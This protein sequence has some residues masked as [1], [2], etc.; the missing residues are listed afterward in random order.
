MKYLFATFSLFFM[1][2]FSACTWVKPVEEAKE[3]ALVKP[4]LAQ[5]CKKIS[6]VT[7]KV[8]DSVGFINR[9]DGKVQD[10]LITMAKN[11]AATLNGDIIVAESGVENG[12]QRFG[13]Y[14][15]D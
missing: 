5:H 2:V 12:R 9:K 3:I 14:G 11:E 10:E 1:L 4:E 6:V 13:V 15:C 8:A 7:V